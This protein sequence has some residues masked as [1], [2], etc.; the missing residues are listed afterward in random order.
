MACAKGEFDPSPSRDLLQHF[1]QHGVGLGASVNVGWD[2][3]NNADMLMAQTEVA[4]KKAS[5]NVSM[6]SPATIASRPTITSAALTRTDQ[7][8]AESASSSFAV[9]NDVV[10]IVLLS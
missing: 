5:L 3:P 8:P 4:G 7:I 2:D 6:D 1:Q 10:V 9:I